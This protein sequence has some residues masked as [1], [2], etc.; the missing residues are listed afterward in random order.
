MESRWN[1][2]G[3]RQKFGW[4][5]CQINSRWNDQ[6]SMGEC[7][8]LTFY[9]SF[10]TRHLLDRYELYFHQV[11]RWIE[12]S[13]TTQNIIRFWSL[14]LLVLNAHCISATQIYMS[15]PIV[16]SVLNAELVFPVC[17]NICSHFSNYG[18][19]HIYM[20]SPAMHHLCHCLNLDFTPNSTEP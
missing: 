11:S 12:Q 6:E 19:S 7:K 20:V 1:P 18:T 2:G 9:H 3:N 5:P 16:M 4:A 17:R 14:Q 13:Y 8:V 15:A 10:F